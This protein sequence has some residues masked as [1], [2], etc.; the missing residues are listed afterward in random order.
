[1]RHRPTEQL[2]AAKMIKADG[3][4]RHELDMLKCLRHPSLP[5]IF[6]ILEVHGGFCL[7]LEYISGKPL[8]ALAGEGMAPEQFF[9]V[10]RQLSG[11][12]LYLH[13]R[14][15]PVLH[16][17]IKPTNILLQP[18][19]RL[20]L[21]DFG[22]AS[23]LKSGTGVC[24][25]YGTPG[26]AAPEQ[27]IPGAYL[28]ARTDLYGFGAVLY[29]CLY[30]GAPEPVRKLPES[31]GAGVLKKLRE[32][33]RSLPGKKRNEKRPG[34][35][36]WKRM[37]RPLL[38][39]CLQENRRKRFSDTSALYRS[40]CRM[41]KRY[42]LARRLRACTAPALLLLLAVSFAAGCLEKGSGA[43]MSEDWKTR[44]ERLLRQADDLG[45]S[46]AVS[47]YEEAASLNPEDGAWCGALLDRIE[48]DCLFSREEEEALKGLIFSVPQGE[49][50]T[51]LE[52]LE[53][54]SGQYGVLAYRIGLDYW[55]FYEAA[56][57]RSAASRWFE[58]AVEAQENNF[59]EADPKAEALR[60]DQDGG[61][62][63][64]DTVSGR[65]AAQSPDW[66]KAARI[67]A[68]I[69]SYYEKLGKQGIDGSLQADAKTYWEDL[70]ELWNL[71][72]CGQELPWI[73]REIAK[74]IMSF[75]IMQTHEL[76]ETG[77]G[78]EKIKNVL[79]EI[80]KFL[81][82][83]NKSDLAEDECGKQYEAAVEAAERVFVNE[84]GK[85]FDKEKKDKQGE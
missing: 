57:G 16:L 63:G 14:K 50:C 18:D 85:Q 29:Y 42:F 34:R 12:L 58:R 6:D 76:A 68:R 67:Y 70:L 5:Q 22:A 60:E 64:G 51:V 56:G 53:K 48:A 17:D 26:F 11:V 25:C 69:S 65:E 15:T 27:K 54:G 31:S 7:I 72:S 61:S 44:Y 35:A 19:G 23:R 46:Q 38:A 81:R 36:L 47:C 73:R 30:A 45:F 33:L 28:D 13:M 9:S 52:L 3:R 4:E 82:E 55:Y 24:A 39:R 77:E 74:E 40:V 1:M 79:G 37:V 59:R 32:R 80:E 83:E 75:L 20:V 78:Q 66:L 21:I 84:R 62:P 49:T 43:E 71:E 2:R 41:E 8:S 10:A